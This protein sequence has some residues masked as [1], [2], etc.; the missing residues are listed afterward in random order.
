MASVRCGSFNISSGIWLA[1]LLT[2][3]LDE[4]ALADDPTNR[5]LGLSALAGFS[6]PSTGSMAVAALISGVLSCLNLGKAVDK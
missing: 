1:T 5:F 6:I 4:E 2:G 3:V